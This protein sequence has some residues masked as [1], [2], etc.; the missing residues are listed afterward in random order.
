MNSR[1]YTLKLSHER[2]EPKKNAFKYSIYLMY[3]DLDELESLA[4]NFTFFSYN[5]WNIFSFFDEDHFKFVNT[6]NATAEKIAQENVKLRAEK[7]LGKNTKERI[8]A[9]IEDLN[10][11][12]DLGK[13]FILTNLR[14]L[15]YIFNPV[16]FYYC[17]DKEGV[18]RVMF[19]EVNNT[20]YDQKIYF[21][22][23]DNPKEKVFTSLQ[24]KNYYISPFLSYD[25]HLKW[26]FDVPGEKMFM[27]V[28]SLKDEKVELKTLLIG[29]RKELSN[30]NLI[31][32]LLRY[33]LIT[34]M[35]IFL[36]HYQALKLWLKKIK[37]YK[38]EETDEKI[39]ADIIK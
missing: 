16:S 2:L 33:P 6:K 13:V 25:N 26:Q 28:N 3:L 21:E 20:F 19:S 7:Y 15:G 12:F 11:S 34:I 1:I 27:S 39:A 23:I 14:N 9:M 31:F 35:I 10:L 18:F 38:K 17:F 4:E 24:K 5:Q 30:T 32:L 8:R 22:V 37:Y 36:I 29:Q